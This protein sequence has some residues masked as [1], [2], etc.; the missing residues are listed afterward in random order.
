MVGALGGYEVAVASHGYGRD[1]WSGRGRSGHR[2]VAVS[3]V[4]RRPRRSARL[5]F[6]LARGAW[7]VRQAWL[8]DSIAARALRPCGGYVLAAFPGFFAARV[9]RQE[10]V[11]S[12]GGLRVGHVGGMVMRRSD[13]FV[14]IRVAGGVVSTADDADVIFVGGATDGG[15]GGGARGQAALVREQWLPD[16]ISQWQRLPYAS[17][18]V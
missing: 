5:L 2:D 18:A 12:L 7:V 1:G 11:T 13:F 10:G 15:A 16:C 8:S 9:A 3:V 17:Y 4:G 6:F 14:L